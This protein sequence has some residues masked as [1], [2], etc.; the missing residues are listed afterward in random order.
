[1]STHTAP[2]RGGADFSSDNAAGLCPEALAALTDAA[3]GFTPAYGDDAIT[4][5]AQAVVRDLLGDDTHVFFVINGTAANTLAI[6]SLT[7]RWERVLCEQWAHLN[8]D[9]STA[10]ELMTGTRL[11]TMDLE[12]GKITAAA[13]RTAA[14]TTMQGVHHPAPGVVSITNTTEHGE[15]YTPAEV[16]AVAD[17]AHQLGY[18]V[19]MDGARFANAV[20]A[21]GCFP[22]ELTTDA[23][24][25]ALSFGGTKN[26]LGLGEA[27]V[28]FGE[29]GARAAERFPW[30]RKGSGHLI[31]KMRYV[32]APF[33]ATV[34]SGAW[35]RHA[36]HANAMADRLASGFASRRC[37][38]AVPDAGQCRVRRTGGGRGG[39]AACPRLGV[40]RDGRPGMAPVPVH[41][42][43][44]N[45]AAAGRR[46]ARGPRRGAGCW[47]TLVARHSRLGAERGRGRQSI[48]A[49]QPSVIARPAAS[50]STMAAAPTMVAPSMV[51]SGVMPRTVVQAEH[52][53]ISPS[54]STS[55]AM[56]SASAGVP[57]ACTSRCAVVPLWTPSM[58][59]MTM[60]L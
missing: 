6:A 58:V 44:R 35:L 19:H 48:L 49:D 17:T 25:D 60:A 2:P 50:A 33:V 23:G 3:T 45:D 22:R 29:A 38:V 10:P 27:V 51:S 9:E 36:A 32:T 42:V 14:G 41:G 37:A 4:A 15:V 1:M 7:N 24:I 55:V 11:T 20:A 18:L 39:R 52:S 46:V 12:G 16:A 8:Q 5:R 13:L 56:R 21:A 31:S 54:L 30:L 43:V 47:L 53:Q 40:L 26:G 59:Q 28:L 57:G 34:E